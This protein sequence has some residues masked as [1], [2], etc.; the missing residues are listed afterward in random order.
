[1]DLLLGSS[2]ADEYIRPLLLFLDWILQLPEELE[3]KLTDDIDN[4]T[5][6]LIMPYIP[7]WERI[8]L[9]KGMKRGLEQGMEEG[10][11]E[12]KQ[13]ILIRLLR[14]KFSLTEKEETL[15]EE[16]NNLNELDSAIDAIL[17]AETKE[18]I[19]S[20]LKQ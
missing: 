14:K 13:Q 7:S 9:K 20:F 6:G 5:G 2:Y 12:D 19:L 10:K 3:E 8:A 16:N 4:T 17:T 15:I 1:M 11:I 18:E